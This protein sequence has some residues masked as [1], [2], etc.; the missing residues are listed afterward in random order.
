MKLDVDKLM[1]EAKLNSVKTSKD[2]NQFKTPKP[3]NIGVSN[4]IK[5]IV[6]PSNENATLKKTAS[7]KVN[8]SLGINSEDSSSID[9][10]MKASNDKIDMTGPVNQPTLFGSSIKA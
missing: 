3:T 1:K 7:L 6:I 8:R 10:A 9:D 5:K 2:D 4:Q